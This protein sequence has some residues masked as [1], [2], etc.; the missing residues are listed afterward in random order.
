M[1]RRTALRWLATA[2]A[3]PL[4]GHAGAEELLAI[5]T[6]LH[7]GRTGGPAG[8][9]LEPH[10]LRTV[11]A[12]AEI[13]L[14]ET[15]TPGATAA[16]VPEFIDRLLAGWF[17]DRQRAAFL[18]GLAGVDVRSRARWACDFV[19]ATP[20]QQT[21]LV[22]ELDAETEALRASEPRRARDEFFAR[23]KWATVYGY[24]TSEPGA[25]RALNY[26]VVPGRFDACV[27]YPAGE[28]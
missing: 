2:T 20:A 3:L 18:A 1:D 23:M 12:I 4:L 24:C 13:I 28:S 10:A 11:A 27:P 26:R 8:R 16:G 25:T 15:D 17:T 9:V 19:D 22:A 6:R 7:T 21:A 14:P 5:G